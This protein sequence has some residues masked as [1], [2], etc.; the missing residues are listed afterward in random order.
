MRMKN[1]SALSDKRMQYYCNGLVSTNFISEYWENVSENNR[2][3][4]QLARHSK[5]TLELL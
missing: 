4:E 5:E 3:S 1:I 2:S